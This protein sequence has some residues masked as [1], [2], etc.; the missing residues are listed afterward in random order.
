MRAQERRKVLPDRK[1]DAKA[2]D[3]QKWP[4]RSFDVKIHRL[5]SCSPNHIIILAWLPKCSSSRQKQGADMS[6]W[7]KPCEIAFRIA[8][9]SKSLIR[10][11]RSYTGTIVW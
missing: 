8:T 1:S 9:K 3:H 4:A 6:A 10:S 5:P 7:L 11:L 2:V